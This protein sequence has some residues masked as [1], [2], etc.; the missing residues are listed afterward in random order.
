MQG[1]NWHSAVLHYRLVCYY[2]NSMSDYPLTIKAAKLTSFL[3]MEVRLL[4]APNAIIFFIYD[5]SLFDFNWIKIL[6]VL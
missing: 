6:M 4:E 3:L 2:S 1:A 5:N